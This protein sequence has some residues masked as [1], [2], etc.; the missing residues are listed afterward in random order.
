VEPFCIVLRTRADF[1]VML[2]V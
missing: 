1:I 2:L